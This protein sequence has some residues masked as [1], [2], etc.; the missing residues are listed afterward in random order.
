M[1][2][3]KVK[4]LRAMVGYNPNRDRTEAAGELNPHVPVGLSKEHP[5]K[6]YA[7]AKKRYGILPLAQVLGRLKS[8][9][10]TLKEDK[11]A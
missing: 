9:V 10:P 5:R 3:K 11:N 8:G 2:G 7:F 6:A 1:R 4:A